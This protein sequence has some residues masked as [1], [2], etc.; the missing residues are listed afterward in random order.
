MG[1]IPSFPIY[2]DWLLK[3]KSYIDSIGGADPYGEGR[4]FAGSVIKKA[5]SLEFKKRVV[6]QILDDARLGKKVTDLK[7][8]QESL[9][10][11]LN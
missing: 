3:V 5:N 1:L 2:E 8:Y 9:I 7:E 10:A 11:R 6:E 4:W